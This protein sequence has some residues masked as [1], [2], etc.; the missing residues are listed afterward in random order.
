MILPRTEDLCPQSPHG[1]PIFASPSRVCNAHRSC[2]QCASDDVTAPTSGKCGGSADS[3]CCN[4]LDRGHSGIYSPGQVGANAQGPYEL[5]SVAAGFW[6][7]GD[8]PLVE[9]SSHPATARAALVQA[10]DRLR[11]RTTFRR[12]MILWRV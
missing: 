4:S 3:C 1:S 8:V 5:D 9:A 12:R 7:R 10:G 6:M 2:S 11:K